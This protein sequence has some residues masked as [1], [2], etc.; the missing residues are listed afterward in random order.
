MTNICVIP[1]RG[2]SRRIPRK[3]IR[4]FFGRP[5]ISYSIET[6]KASGLFDRIFVS[7]DDDEIANIS[8][9]YGSE[10]IMR[11]ES[12]SQDE[13]GTQEVTKHAIEVVQE[14]LGKVDYACCIYA[15]APMMIV[16]DLK[17]GFSLLNYSTM[18]YAMS[19]G[20]EPLRDAGQWYLGYASAFL[21]NW[22]LIDTLTYMVPIPANRVCDINTIQDFERAEQMFAN[23][24]K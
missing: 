1:A 8:R 6:A 23:I 10:V 4:D 13:V 22:P 19:V 20:T 3:N 12:F 18:N 11:P 15:T 14:K 24:H 21:H 7:T 16:D 2:G 9:E 5:I 17:R